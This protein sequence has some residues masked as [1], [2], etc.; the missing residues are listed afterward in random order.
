MST[1]LH[2]STGRLLHSHIPATVKLLS[3]CQWC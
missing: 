1:S 2:S 3:L